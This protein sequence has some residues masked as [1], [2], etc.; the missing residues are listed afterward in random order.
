MPSTIPIASI[1]ADSAET[2]GLKWAAPASGGKILQVVEGSTTSELS[3]S[4]STFADTNLSATITPSSA[5]SK[6]LVLVAQAGLYKNADNS[7]NRVDVR[8]MRGATELIKAR[9]MLWTNSAV[10]NNGV[11]HTIV[12]LDS[13]AT[14]S[15]TTYKTQFANPNSTNLVGVQNNAIKSIIVLLE[16][17]A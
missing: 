11:N 14:T 5:S 15:A 9:D 17:G 13:P 7:M 8:L 1:V 6:V 16:V 12:Y 3:S 10:T 2:T 4:S